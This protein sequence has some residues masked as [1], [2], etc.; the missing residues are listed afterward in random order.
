MRMREIMMVG[1]LVGRIRS[2][3]YSSDDAAIL[4]VPGAAL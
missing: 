1:P 3:T 2:K 4:S